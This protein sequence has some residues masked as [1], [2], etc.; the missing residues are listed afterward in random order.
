MMYVVKSC[1]VAPNGGCTSVGGPFRCGLQHRRRHPALAI[2]EA[3]P[4]RYLCTEVEMSRAARFAAIHSIEGPR[5]SLA[6]HGARL[7]I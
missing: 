3:L 1:S 6:P 7:F 5:R 2:D 4:Q